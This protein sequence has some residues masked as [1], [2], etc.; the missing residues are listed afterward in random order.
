M[1]AAL[2]GYRLWDK[3]SICLYDFYKQF[4]G[5]Y[6]ITKYAISN[7]PQAAL[8]AIEMA[9]WVK[10]TGRS[11]N[12]PSDSYPWTGNKNK[13]DHAKGVCESGVIIP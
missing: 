9:A 1:A 5:Q 3:S 11:G 8:H 13:C 7:P 2:M 4:S 10:S 12:H 6:L